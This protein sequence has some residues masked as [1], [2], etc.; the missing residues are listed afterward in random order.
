MRFKFAFLLLLV[1]FNAGLVAAQDSEEIAYGD[2]VEGEI[3][4]DEFEVFYSFQGE[5]GDIVIIE[6]IP[7]LDNYDLDPLVALLDED[8]DEIAT[9]DDF[10][11]HYPIPVL[12]HQLED[13]GTFYIQATRL[14]IEDSDDEGDFTL[15]LTR[16]EPV[17]LNSTVEATIY[18]NPDSEETAVPQ[19]FILAPEDDATVSITVEQEGDDEFFAGVY[20]GRVDPEVYG[21]VDYLI[22]MDETQ[23]AS[24]VSFVVELDN[25]ELYVLWAQGSPSVYVYDDIEQIVNFTLAEQ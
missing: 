1:L 16:A 19:L 5:E 11:N 23:R 7:E 13:S 14:G 22:D 18:A 20:L 8:E 4:D 2:V 24:S 3:T 12:I 6:M 17:D 15:R 25:N 21:G 9:N 10:P